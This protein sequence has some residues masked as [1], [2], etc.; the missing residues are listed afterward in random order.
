MRK[1]KRT[2]LSDVAEKAGVSRTAAAYILSKTRGG[3]AK[4]TVERVTNAAREFGFRPN[5]IARSLQSVAAVFVVIGNPG[6]PDVHSVDVDNVW[7]GRLTTQHLIDFGHRRLAYIAPGDSYA[8]GNDRVEG[9]LLAC[10]EASLPER[11]AIVIRDDDSMSGGYRAMQELLQVAPTVTGVCAVDD[12]MAYGAV[13]AINDAGLSVPNDISIVGCNND[14]FMATDPDFLT[15]VNLNFV[16]LGSA[17]TRK[18][19]ALID[20]R[21]VSPRD[22]ISDIHLICRKSS[23]PPKS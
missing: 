1:P 18:L 5:P 7:V 12:A 16:E 15:T 2:T 8:Y 19:F 20:H 6:Y 10:K 4:E 11:D 13:K 23:A 3:F 14:F 17:A 22:L 9:F 21:D